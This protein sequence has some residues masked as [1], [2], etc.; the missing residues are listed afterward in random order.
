MSNKLTT[1]ALMLT[2]TLVACS[3]K[4]ASF[5]PLDSQEQLAIKAAKKIV[6][7][8]ATEYYV[9]LMTDKGNMV[10]KLYNQTP[11]HRDN[12]VSKV[13]AGFYDSLLFHRVIPDFMMQGGDPNSRHA[14]AGMAL[15]NGSAPGEKI[16][17]ELR[18]HMGIYHK[19]GA[20]AAAHDGNAEKASNNCQFYVVQHPAWSLEA[21]RAEEARRG[22]QLSPEQVKTYT[23]VGGMPH[24]DNRYTV[25]GET[26]SGIAVA[27]SIV[28]SPRDSRNRP[29]TDIRMKAFLLNRIK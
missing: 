7:K 20:L 4:I 8:K 17:A 13:Q 25:F 9:L 16:P 3:P 1:L 19:R 26:V 28:N 23:S 14:P 10:L 5:R 24:L 6:P 21:L 29:N 12:F 11:L 18:T 27:D 15:G 22:I 2:C